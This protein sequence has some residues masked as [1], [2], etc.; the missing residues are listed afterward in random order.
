MQAASE[1]GDYWANTGIIGGLQ[2]FGS[3]LADLFD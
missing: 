2:E 1:S 3:E